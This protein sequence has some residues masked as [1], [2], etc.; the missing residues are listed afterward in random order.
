[1]FSQTG[2]DGLGIGG[3]ELAWL[4]FGAG[5]RP[6]G[7]VTGSSPHRGGEG[8]LTGKRGENTPADTRGRSQ[9]C[10]ARM[11]DYLDVQEGRYRGEGRE[12]KKEK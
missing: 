9:G 2:L 8:N 12:V 3:A 11:Q 10:R 4:P 6:R 7:L 5:R 1:M